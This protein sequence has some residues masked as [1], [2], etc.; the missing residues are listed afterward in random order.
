M[1]RE[2]YLCKLAIQQS[3]Q[4]KEN[5]RIHEEQQLLTDYR[6]MFLSGRDFTFDFNGVILKQVEKEPKKNPQV[7]Y[8]ISGLPSSA[9][10]Q[11]KKLKKNSIFTHKKMSVDK[12][13]SN[14]SGIVD[15]YVQ[16]GEAIKITNKKM[17]SRFIK[18]DMSSSKDSSLFN[19]NGMR[20]TTFF[21]DIKLNENVVYKENQEDGSTRAI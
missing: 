4:E 20:Q 9:G 8:Q 17:D 10:D 12:E 16:N 1:Y 5:K 19:N 15:D 21:N 18:T 11:L 6:K 14:H 2:D 7:T 3:L 13:S